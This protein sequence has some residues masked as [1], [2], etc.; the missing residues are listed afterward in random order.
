MRI[1][2]VLALGALVVSVGTAG[3]GAEGATQTVFLFNADD[4]IVHMFRSSDSFSAE[5]RLQ[6]NDGRFVAIR[7]DDIAFGSV[8]IIAGRDGVILD[9]I[10][11]DVASEDVEEIN[12][13]SV[14]W[15]GQSLS[16]TNDETS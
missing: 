15:D 8:T 10:L 13:E 5:N 4:E 3:C 16:C 1:I 7:G 12:L 14:T 6:P 9:Q 2:A 11:C